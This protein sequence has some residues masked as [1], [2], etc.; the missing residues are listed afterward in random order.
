MNWKFL[1]IAL[2]GFTLVACDGKKEEK[3]AGEA[4]PPDAVMKAEEPKVTTPT[5]TDAPKEEPK[6]EEPEVKKE[7][8][9]AS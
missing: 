5:P 8:S 6:K 3:K 2:L 4:T 7:E 9:K 1:S